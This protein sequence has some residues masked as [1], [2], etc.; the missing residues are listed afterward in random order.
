MAH[1]HLEDKDQAPKKK[2]NTKPLGLTEGLHSLASTFLSS[3]IS[4]VYPSDLASLPLQL[5]S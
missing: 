2:Q 4:Y 1:Y 5:I 3:L